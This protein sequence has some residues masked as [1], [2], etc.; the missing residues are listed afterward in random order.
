VHGC[1]P[2]VRRVVV[3]GSLVGGAVL[4]GLWGGSVGMEQGIERVGRWCDG[5]GS[6][7]VACGGDSSV[8]GVRKVHQG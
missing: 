3:M 2:R 8:V 1:I 6:R 7:C 5:G 4:I